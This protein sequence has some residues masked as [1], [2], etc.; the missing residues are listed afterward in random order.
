LSAEKEVDVYGQL[1]LWDISE[2]PNVVMRQSRLE[3]FVYTLVTSPDGVTEAFYMA[4]LNHFMDHLSPR[5]KR[6]VLFYMKKVE[7]S[8]GVFVFKFEP[9]K[10]EI[11]AGQEIW[12]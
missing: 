3:E 11:V 1:Y 4:I 9:L 8:E 7:V 6:S 5:F 10:R 2:E 12:S